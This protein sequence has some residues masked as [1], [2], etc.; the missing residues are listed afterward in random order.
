M[1]MTAS[2]KKNLA[3]GK[4]ITKETARKMQAKSV[5]SHL[6]ERNLIKAMECWIKEG[7]FVDEVDKA[8]ADEKERKVILPILI[9]KA[10]PDNINVNATGNMRRDININFRRATPEDAK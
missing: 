5:V 9:K 4:R 10:L 2:Q 7:R 3:K 8:L 1:A 6:K